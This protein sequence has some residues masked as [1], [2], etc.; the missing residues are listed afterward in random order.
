MRQR[1]VGGKRVCLLGG[2]HHNGI[3]V[4][5]PI[6]DAAEVHKF[7][8]LRVTLRRGIEGELVDVAKHTDILIRMRPL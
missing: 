5:R 6:E 1:Q 4:I 2:G 8:G 7:P 3:K